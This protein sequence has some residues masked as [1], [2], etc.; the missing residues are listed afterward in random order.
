[1]PKTK[2]IIKLDVIALINGKYTEFSNNY[3]F[4]FPNFSTR[5][6]FHGEIKNVMYVD[7]MKY[8]KYVKDNH[9]IHLIADFLNSKVGFLNYQLSGLNVIKDV[10]DNKF[11]PVNI[12]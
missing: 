12:K 3:Y 6:N 7:Y 5:P 8:L 2:S 9:N 4:M 11:K 1:M 10:I